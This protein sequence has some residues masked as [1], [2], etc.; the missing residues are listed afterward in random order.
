MVVWIEEVKSTSRFETTYGI[1]NHSGRVA[2]TALISLLS[3]KM[4][5]VSFRVFWFF[6]IVSKIDFWRWGDII[7]PFFDVFLQVFF[8]NWRGV[9]FFGVP[10]FTHWGRCSELW[11]KRTSFVHFFL[12]FFCFDFFKK[13]SQFRTKNVRSAHN[14]PDEL[15][16]LPKS[17][18]NAYFRFFVVF[19]DSLAWAPQKE[20]LR[21]WNCVPRIIRCFWAQLYHFFGV[22][23]SFC[24]VSVRKSKLLIEK[25]QKILFFW[26]YLRDFLAKKFDFLTL[27]V[28]NNYF[29]TKLML[30]LCSETSNYP[31]GTISW[32]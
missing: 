3:T 9:L 17:A 8:K 13:Q 1:W 24:A 31:W 18:E 30:E 2:L 5:G 6:K 32:P 16:P 22:E 25:T 7:F 29:N 15:Q 14:L 27:L 12:F 28:R 20:L 23:I 4:L 26:M 10:N 11:A 21:S 19:C